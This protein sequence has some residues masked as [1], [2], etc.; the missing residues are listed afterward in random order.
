MSEG[1]QKSERGR[2]GE[3][4]RDG[5]YVLPHLMCSDFVTSCD[6]CALRCAS[7]SAAGWRERGVFSCRLEYIYW[8]DRHPPTARHSATAVIEKT[9]PIP[10]HY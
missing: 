10:H 7:R 8:A 5:D 9:L 6:Q 2:V 3:R 4:G 1:K